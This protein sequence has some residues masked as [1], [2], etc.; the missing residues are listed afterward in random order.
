M[1]VTSFSYL[2]GSP[3]EGAFVL[4][5]RHLPN[6]QRQPEL[7]ALTGKD[8]AVQNFVRECFGFRHVM[9]LAERA[10]LQGKHVAFGCLGGRHR[11]VALAELLAEQLRAM[12]VSVQVEHQDLER[13]E[14]PSWP[15]QLSLGLRTF[16]RR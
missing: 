9:H 5:C 6:P 12:G 4:D 15:A 10:A 8:H 1:R 14:K 16:P 11:S 13:A 3:P 7:R 2:R